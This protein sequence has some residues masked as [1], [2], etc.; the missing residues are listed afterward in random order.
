VTISYTVFEIKRDNSRK[1]QFL[2]ISSF[3]IATSLGT[4]LRILLRYFSKPRQIPAYQ[5][6]CVLTAQARNRQTGKR[7]L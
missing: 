3:Y 1:S 2:F 7:S 6:L 4:R 5:V